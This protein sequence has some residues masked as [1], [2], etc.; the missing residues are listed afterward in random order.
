MTREVVVLSAVRSAIGSF[1]GGLSQ[2]EPPELAGQVLGTLIDRYLDDGNAS[3]S[4]WLQSRLENEVA[5]LIR[6]LKVSSWDYSR[7]MS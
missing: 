6:G 7:R 1:G 2:I 4:E 5:I 3:L